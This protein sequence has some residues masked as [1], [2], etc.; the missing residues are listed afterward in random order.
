M[1]LIAILTLTVLFFS[2]RTFCPVEKA[3]DD[4]FTQVMKISTASIQSGFLLEGD[5]GR[6]SLKGILPSSKTLLTP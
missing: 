3:F 2:V 4:A 5:R 6:L 1:L